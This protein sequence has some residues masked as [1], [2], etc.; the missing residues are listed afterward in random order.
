MFL[1][2][3]K[4]DQVHN[5]LSCLDPQNNDERPDVPRSIFKLDVVALPT[6]VILFPGQQDKVQNNFLVL[7]SNI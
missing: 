2:A 5:N 3:G 6:V 4:L 7:R 1:S